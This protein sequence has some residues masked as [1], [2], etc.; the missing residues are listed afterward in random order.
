MK[1]YKLREGYSN[2][3]E[4]EFH[5]IHVDGEVLELWKKPLKHAAHSP[6]VL[7]IQA[8]KHISG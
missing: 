8:Q 4:L 5:L 6:V 3:N 7:K 1:S 2:I